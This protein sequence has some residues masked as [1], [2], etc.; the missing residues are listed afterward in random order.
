MVSAYTIFKAIH[1][2]ASVVWVGG[3]VTINLLGARVVRCSEAVRRIGFIRDIDWMGKYVY[4]PAS[5]LVL[6]FGIV[7]ALEGHLA[8][9]SAWLLLGI[10][11]IALT[12]LTGMLFFLPEGRRILV[13]GRQRGVND[14][15]IH[16]RLRRLLRVARV[17]L[18]VLLLVVVDMVLKPGG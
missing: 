17:D 7:A 16:Q 1:V 5:L 15:E 9:R 18:I 2:L 6:L 14:P 11:G 10:V 12:A 13:I 3:G 4:L 8:F